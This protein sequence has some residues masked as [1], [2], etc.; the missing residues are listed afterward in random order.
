MSAHVIARTYVL[1]ECRELVALPGG[2]YIVAVDGSILDARRK[3]TRTEA[4]SWWDRA[5]Y[6]LG[7]RPSQSQ[8][9]RAER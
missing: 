7:P 3:L 2:R 6:R 5:A 9:Q 4:A 1:T 8:R